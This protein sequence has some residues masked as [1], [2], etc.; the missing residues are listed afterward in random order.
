MAGPWRGKLQVN[1]QPC[2]LAEVDFDKTFDIAV[3]AAE[4]LGTKLSD[5][6]D[7][8]A[9][10]LQLTAKHELRGSFGGSAWHYAAGVRGTCTVHVFA[11]AEDVDADAIFG[12]LAHETTTAAAALSPAPGLAWLKIAISGEA[13]GKVGTSRGPARLAL[14]GEGSVGLGAYFPVSSSG[15]LVNALRTTGEI[16]FVL[17]ASDVRR[18]GIGQAAYV[19]LGGS[20]S[21]KLEF[22]WA[23]LLTGPI[24][25]LQGLVAG[26]RPLNLAVDLQASVAVAFAISDS[27][28]LVFVGVDRDYVAVS[29]NRASSNAFSVKG[30]VEATIRL[31]KPDMARDLL[32]NLAAQLLG[33]DP[34]RLHE[35]RARL[36][37]VLALFDDASAVL[38]AEID[39]LAVKLDAAI[40]DRGM[41]VFLTRLHQLQ[42]LVRLGGGADSGLMAVGVTLGQIDK[43][44]GVFDGLAAR[45]AT[46][47]GSQ[48]DGLLADLRL[49]PLLQ[50]AT[51][52]ARGL[53]D[54]LAKLEAGL[55]KIAHARIELG[56][57]VEYRRIA[58][59]ASVLKLRLR[60]SHG[61][62][63]A[64]HQS[65]L[66]LDAKSVLDAA[67]PANEDIKLELFLN[68]KSIRRSL[69][70]GIDL[71]WVYADKDSAGTQWTESTRMV[72]GMAA[73]AALRVE[74]QL[75][76]KGSRSRE[77][78]VFGTQSQCSGQFHAGFVATGSADA[79]G[80]WK[81]ALS[82]AYASGIR[83]A[84]SAW[85]LALADYA[86]VWGVIQ[87][88][89][90]DWLVKALLED[91]ALGTKVE[92]EI[93]LGIGHAAFDVPAFLKSFGAATD[94]D[95]SCA[96]AV[97]LQRLDSF[98]ERATPSARVAAY[99]GAVSVLLGKSGID[100]S[101]SVP[102]AKYVARHL[103][104]PSAVLRAFEMQG[105]APLSP[106]SV[107]D[108]CQRVGSA[109][110]AIREFENVAALA[111]LAGV[112]SPGS[113]AE[114]KIVAKAF[115]G[116][117]LA[118]RD[119][120][121]LRWQVSLLR[122]LAKRAGVSGH[123]SATMKV[124]VGASGKVRIF[125]AR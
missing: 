70:L 81:F 17:D 76:L 108:M 105:R 90:I 3:G 16:P 92:M 66:G 39:G 73:N 98:P 24:T 101:K 110:G 20:L 37:T 93:A 106:G 64:W 115:Q 55:L 30:G 13:S 117:D 104:T 100:V 116:L 31:E 71:G 58:S 12:P 5:I 69:S 26:D 43:A 52:A 97:A 62:F 57:D 85:L 63:E 44:A 32:A 10:T 21:A 124:T 2:R 25:A 51:G 68:Q 96:L 83:R 59:D 7:K 111:S 18:L 27:F 89:E 40:D 60:R 1:S 123:T 112:A 72:A 82:L 95:L 121:M 49:P 107:V 22:S 91:G 29:L 74:R 28:R 84:D 86:A 23:D 75:A 47:I 36:E 79:T 80:H 48:L 122:V 99:S 87:E 77:E 67:S 11:D 102:V 103:N 114:R 65:L 46:E 6:A 19:A 33:V 42:A 34:A 35:V 78:S 4:A 94:A 56:L 38:R 9:P 54:R 61:N 113:A 15:T 109:L 53:L 50:D 8:G 88:S 45:L 120:F 119:R 14:S 125:A 41:P 118:W